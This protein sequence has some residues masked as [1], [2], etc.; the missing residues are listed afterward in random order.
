MMDAYVESNG[1]S[2]CKALFVL[3]KASIGLI[4]TL[5]SKPTSE[6]GFAQDTQQKYE[7]AKAPAETSIEFNPKYSIFF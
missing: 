1:N 2:Y 7:I 4:C 3:F 5:T 6:L